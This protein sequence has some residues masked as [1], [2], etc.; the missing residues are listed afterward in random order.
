MVEVLPTSNSTLPSRLGEFDTIAEGLDYA[1][2]GETGC[3]FFSSRGV[4]LESLS[5]REIRERAIGLA[6]AFDAAKMPRGARMAIIAETGP[7]FLIFFH[8]CQYAGLI[9]VPLPLSVNLGGHEAYVARLRN[10]IGRAGALGGV[11]SA[12]LIGYLTEA[13]EGL[14]LRWLGTPETFYA[15]PSAGGDL[16]PLGKD[17]ACY[18]QYSSGSTSMPRGVLVSQ[19]AITHNVRAIGQH[20]LQ[21][22]PGDRATSWLPLYHDMGLVGFCLSPT[23]SQV[24][25]D[26]MA[27]TTFA[28]R[29][30]LWLKI[31]SDYGGTISFSP[32][33][34]YELCVRLAS[35]VEPGQFDLSNWRIAGIGGEMVRP[36]VL[37]AFA[38]RFADCGFDPRAFLPSYGLAESTLAVSFSPLGAGVRAD[39]VSREAYS[40]DGLAVPVKTNGNGAGGLREGDSGRED[41]AFVKCGGPLPGHRVEIRDQEN[42]ALPERQ[43]GWVC[44]QGPSLMEGYFADEEAT[45]SVF[46]ADGWLNTG[47]MGYLVDGE[48]V[49]TGRFKDLII[50]N[51]RNIWPQDL[52]WAVESR[53][54]PGLGHAAA[55]SVDDEDGKEQVVVVVECR[56]RAPEAQAALRRQITSVVSTVAGVGGAI[57][58]APPRTLTFT[59][60]GK[61]SRV[62]AKADYL[63]DRIK[64]MGAESQ[65]EAPP[66]TA[67]APLAAA[68]GR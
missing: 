49:I 19:R 1:A 3:S 59:S 36:A 26:Y 66:E 42:R 5:Y 12:E 48:L 33:F 64:D 35:R 67:V 18:V 32:T 52:E 61:L 46:T 24:T 44:I 53:C 41:R 7:D 2:R 63:A 51:G 62:A 9:P 68:A 38:E 17:E 34:G 50:C 40:R 13:A 15:L 43:I 11:A 60:S 4:L 6:L 16:R 56:I 30:M 27:S 14:D 23:L 22:R 55:F 58:L 20:G 54:G 39:R 8:A 47:D 28:R 37:N 10:L 25:I 45:R 31:L 65:D 29:P 57:V 21:L